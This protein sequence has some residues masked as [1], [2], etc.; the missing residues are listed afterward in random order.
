MIETVGE[1]IEE[2]KKYPPDTYVERYNESYDNYHDDETE[3]IQGMEYK[4]TLY[5][6]VIIR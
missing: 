5:K 3:D 4:D 1:L 2:L 6:V